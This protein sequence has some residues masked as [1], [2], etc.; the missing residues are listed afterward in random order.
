MDQQSLCFNMHLQRSPK[1]HIYRFIIKN[2]PAYFESVNNSE[3][4]DDY[5]TDGGNPKDSDFTLDSEGNRRKF[6][7]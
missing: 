5:L 4:G 6:T 1:I 2:L 3:K 7:R